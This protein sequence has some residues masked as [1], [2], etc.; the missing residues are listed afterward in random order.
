LVDASVGW[1]A[2]S[3][4]W[5]GSGREESNCWRVIWEESI[6][7][8]DK[9]TPDELWQR[10]AEENPHARDDE[11]ARLFIA[12]TKDNE[13]FVRQITEWVFNAS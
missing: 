7:M 3:S 11:I 13:D 4:R 9:A 6:I 5:N 1:D 2:F 12:A 8:A 10:I